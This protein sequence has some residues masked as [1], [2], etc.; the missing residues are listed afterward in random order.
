[1]MV[2][3]GHYDGFFILCYCQSFHRFACVVVAQSPPLAALLT[4]WTL[5]SLLSDQLQLLRAEE[6]EAVLWCHQYLVTLSYCHC[7]TFISEIVNFT[8]ENQLPGR[9]LVTNSRQPSKEV[10]LKT[11]TFSLPVKTKVRAGMF[12]QSRTKV[13]IERSSPTRIRTGNFIP[14]RTRAKAVSLS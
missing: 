2:I 1:M 5:P 14:V 13:K 10:F 6:S 7:I 8:F 12:S 3:I 4:T 9:C 11:G